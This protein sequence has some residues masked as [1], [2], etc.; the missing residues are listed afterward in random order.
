MK[1]KVVYWDLETSDLFA[2][3]GHI[4]CVGYEVEGEG[5]KHISIDQ[6][7]GWQSQPWNDFF[8]CQA[9]LKVLQREDLGVEVTHYGTNF[10]L[11]FLQARLKFHGLGTIPPLGHEDTY[12]IA[13]SKLALKSRRLG[14]IAEFLKIRFKKTPIDKEHW[15]RAGRGDKGSLQYIIKHCIADIRVLKAVY[16]RLAPL[17]KKPP[18]I[19]AWKDCHSCGSTRLHRRGYGLS[20]KSGR[21]V[22]LQCQEC[23]AWSSRLEKIA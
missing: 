2:D 4:F 18:V 15:R 5:I 21:T 9:F 12:F 22:K 17:R 7:P 23:G 1:R 13:K 11:K 16:K 3:W 10:D 19:G 14:S 20:L 8:V 6:F